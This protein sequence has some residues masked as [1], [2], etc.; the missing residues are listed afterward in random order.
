MKKITISYPDDQF[1]W[2][3]E[4]PEFNKS[5]A[6][7]AIIGYMMKNDKCSLTEVDLKAIAESIQGA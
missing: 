1:E 7:R 6:F 4:H 5:G 2:L 3:E